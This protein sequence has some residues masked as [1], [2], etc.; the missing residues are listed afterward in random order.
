MHFLSLITTASLL[1]FS[2]HNVAAWS[3]LG[4]RTVALLAHK[5][6]DADTIQTLNDILANDQG[7]DFSDAAVWADT[8]K[9]G[10]NARPWTKS[11]HYIGMCS[12]LECD[13]VGILIP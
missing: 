13:N 7:Y 4:H 5:Y 12:S 11:W 10:R 2:P 8:I 9:R 1:L 3:D 6:L